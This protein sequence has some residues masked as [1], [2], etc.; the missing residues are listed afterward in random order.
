MFWYRFRCSLTITFLVISLPFS[1][2]YTIIVWLTNFLTNTQQSN[3]TAVT[4]ASKTVMITGGKMGKSL[5]FERWM[6]KNGYKVVLVETEKYCYPGS[7]WS[8]A[9]TIFE[10]VT[11]PRVNSRKYVTDL[12]DVAVRHK[13]DY[14]IPVSSPIASLICRT[15]RQSL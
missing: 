11:C 7:R 3:R 13:V 6:W 14:F 15:A 4:D 9:V 10:T 12:V 8:R 1:V 2:L 5:H